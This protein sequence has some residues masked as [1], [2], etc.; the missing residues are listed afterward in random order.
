M[1]A[2]MNQRLRRNEAMLSRQSPKSLR[3]RRTSPR[4]CQPV[5]QYVASLNP[6]PHH[7]IQHA[8][9]LLLVGA[10]LSVHSASASTCAAPN[11]H[12]DRSEEIL[13]HPYQVVPDLGRMFEALRVHQLDLLS[14][15]YYVPGGSKVE[16][17]GTQSTCAQAQDTVGDRSSDANRPA[18][19]AESH[20]RPKCRDHYRL[21][22]TKDKQMAKKS[23]TASARVE[24]WDNAVLEVGRKCQQGSCNN[25]FQVLDRITAHFSGTKMPR[26]AAKNG[27]Q[28][29]PGPVAGRVTAGWVQPRRVQRLPSVDQG[30][31]RK[32]STQD[33]RPV[34]S[35]GVERHELVDAAG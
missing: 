5:A 3:L 23:R 11:A 8:L 10:R 31:G 29:P 2:R 22:A 25:G 1:A 4:A 34:I 13:L 27:A 7:F 33:C 6:A 26:A 20:T 17:L 16:P 35:A 24:S 15:P 21:T 32:R 18:S 14:F 28:C 19:P 12:D 30:E 9:A